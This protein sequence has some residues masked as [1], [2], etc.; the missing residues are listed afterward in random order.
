MQWTSPWGI[1]DCFLPLALEDV[2]K[3]PLC[4]LCKLKTY[5]QL[6]QNSEKTGPAAVN[7]SPDTQFLGA[8]FSLLM[9]ICSLS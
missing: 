6:F 3:Y 2:V 4:A 9:Y 7:S 5:T 8:F 1:S